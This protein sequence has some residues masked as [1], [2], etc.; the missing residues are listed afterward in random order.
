[1]TPHVTTVV[2]VVVLTDISA[3]DGPQTYVTVQAGCD[4]EAETLHI[5]KMNNP[6]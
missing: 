5:F 2:V 6:F 3:S 1:M 4:D